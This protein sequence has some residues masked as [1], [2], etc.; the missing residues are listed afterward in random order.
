[1]TGVFEKRA[2]EKV[3]GEFLVSFNLNETERKI[4][5]TQ[6]KAKK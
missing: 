5:K 4:R 3:G 6:K 1:M 2:G